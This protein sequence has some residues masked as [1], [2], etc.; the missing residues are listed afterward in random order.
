MTGGHAI[1]EIEK[2][3]ETR[4]ARYADLLKTLKVTVPFQYTNKVKWADENL[5]FAVSGEIGAPGSSRPR[6]RARPRRCPR[7][8]NRRR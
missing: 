4:S 6:S 2:Q 1:S 8:A 5:T 7:T 3:R